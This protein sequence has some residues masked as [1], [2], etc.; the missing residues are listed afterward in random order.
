MKRLRGDPAGWGLTDSAVAIGVF[1]GLHRG[2]QSVIQALDAIAPPAPRVVL[3]FSVHP[4][5]VLAP[6]GAPLALTT[7]D[8]RLELLEEIGVEAV[9]VL[10]FDDELRK[11][12][13]ADFVAR[14]LDRGLGAHYVAV[15]EGFRFGYEASGDTATLRRLGE[16]LGFTVVTVP[17]RDLDGRPIRSTAIR[18]AVRE[19]DVA[20][21]RAMLGRP[22]EIEGI[23]VPGDGRG[24]QIGVP[25]ANIDAEGMVIPARGVYA[26][27]GFING[28]AVPGVA[29]IGVRPTFEGG[30]EVVEVHLLDSEIDLYHHRLRI[31]F[32]ARLRDERRFDSVDDL[33]GQIQRDIAETRTV[34]GP[35]APVEDRKTG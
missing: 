11:M 23:V 34:V 6:V 16:A 5:T 9:A 17:I 26:V 21:A 25:T 10:D 32:I 24:R 8:R 15:G 33:V 27:R 3:T 4:A 18:N 29:N 2:H 20:Q 30:P 19:G 13:P 35:E 28:K 31:E 14:Y 12:A 7:L 22:H 1:D